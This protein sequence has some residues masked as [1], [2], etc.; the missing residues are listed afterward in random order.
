MSTSE[1][2]AVGAPFSVAALLPGLS[3][4]LL[5]PEGLFEVPCNESVL[6]IGRQ[7]RFRV[8]Y[9]VAHATRSANPMTPS[10]SASGTSPAEPGDQCGSRLK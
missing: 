8:A 5:V 4:R 3:L 6:S 7:F 2:G 1:S 10:L 9:R